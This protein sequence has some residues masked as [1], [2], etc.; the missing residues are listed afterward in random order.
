VVL[1]HLNGLRLIAQVLAA[2][3]W[4][5]C[6]DGDADRYLQDLTALMNLASQLHDGGILVTELISLGIR[7]LALDAVDR[8]LAA[9]PDLLTDANLQWIAHKLAGPNVAADL[10]DLDGERLIFY[11]W[12]QR[13]YT[14]DGAGD[15][16]LTP[17]GVRLL[18]TLQLNDGINRDQSLLQ[19]AISATAPLT[20]ASRQQARRE[21]DQALDT[22]EA[23]FNCPLRDAPWGSADDQEP[24]GIRAIYPW[25]HPTFVSGLRNVQQSAERYLGQRDGLLVGISLE[26]HRRASGNYPDHL[27]ALVPMP[28]PAVPADRI[29]GEPVRYRLKNGRPLIYSVG[30]DR[31]DDKGTVPKYRTVNQP[32]VFGAAEWRA[33]PATALDGDWVLFPVPRVEEPDDE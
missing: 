30:A 24:G 25:P 17:V 28:L 14:D 20:V 31:D 32:W 9:A 5:A 15:G 29:T 13:A 16:R 22:V 1:P 6:R 12:L 2:E 7:A 4:F 21:Y 8:M 18:A 10:I 27:E 19:T 33:D 23:N 11:D 3:A 26:L